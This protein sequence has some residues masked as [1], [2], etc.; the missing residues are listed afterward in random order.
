MKGP[1]SK[2]QPRD[3]DCVL[4][5]GHDHLRHGFFTPTPVTFN[6]PDG[7]SGCASWMICCQDC[8]VKHDSQFFVRDDKVWKGDEPCF[9]EYGRA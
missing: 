4:T 2:Q 1:F 3:G 9:R 8:F 7:S 5:C 6:R